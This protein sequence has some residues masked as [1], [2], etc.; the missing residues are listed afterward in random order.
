M[1]F[2]LRNPAGGPVL[3]AIAFLHRTN[4]LACWRAATGSFHLDAGVPREILVVFDQRDPGAC[5]TP[6]EIAT[7]KLVVEGPVE[8]ASLQEWAIRYDLRP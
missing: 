2:R 6:S 8:T 3:D 1:R 7:M 5:A 4:K